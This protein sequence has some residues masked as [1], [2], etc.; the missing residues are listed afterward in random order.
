M[1]QTFLEKVGKEVKKDEKKGLTFLDKIFP[2]YKK[3][4]RHIGHFFTRIKNGTISG[5]ADVD[6]TTII[7][8]IQAGAATGFSLLWLVVLATPLLIAIEE[9]TATLAVV[10]KK[11][12][13]R[14]VKEKLGFTVGVFLVSLVLIAAVATIGADL[15]AMIDILATAT[16]FPDLIIILMLLIIF[17]LLL[18]RGSYAFVS[19]FLYLLTPLLLLFVVSAIL[20]HPNWHEV[21]VHTFSPLSGMG[22]KTRLLALALLGDVICPYIVFWQSIEEIEEKKQIK[23]LKNEKLGVRFGMI[24][25]S[26][27][28]FFVTVVAGT[29]LFKDGSTLINSAR[30]AAAALGP[31]LGN[32][33]FLIFGIALLASGLVSIPVLAASGAYVASDVFDW[34]EGLGKKI[35]QAKGFY[36]VLIVALF[37]GSAINLLGF[38]PIKLVVYSQALNGFLMP[39]ILIVLLK[40]GFDKKIVGGYTP[41]IWI[42]SLAYL[43]LILFIVL[44]ILIFV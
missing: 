43:T 25:S 28:F 30:D 11:G 22:D 5:A 17:V 23:D 6:P 36:I 31:A 42:K 10:T 19:R 1:K 18:F 3:Q 4:R 41:S 14:L 13:S 40:L 12:F 35:A 38:H 8:R 26:V 37:L 15:G 44:D 16:G 32:F 33:S 21:W 2:I 20:A 34:K 9:I 24:F 27:I 39:F 29:V 7:T